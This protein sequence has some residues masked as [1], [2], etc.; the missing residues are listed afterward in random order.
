MLYLSDGKIELPLLKWGD[1]DRVVPV[2]GQPKWV[3]QAEPLATVEHANFR[4]YLDT[5]FAWTDAAALRAESDELTPEKLQP[6]AFFMHEGPPAEVLVV[7]DVA[8][9]QQTGERMMMLAQALNPAENI[10]IIRPSRDAAWFPVRTDQPIIV[11]RA[12]P[13]G[14]KEL[15]RMKR[16]HTPPEVACYGELCPK[17]KPQPKKKR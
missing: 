16:L 17:D 3:R 8:S 15:R 9:S 10:H 1:G 2:G 5:V 4:D 13:Y 12:K 11:P 14:W 7:I 6:G